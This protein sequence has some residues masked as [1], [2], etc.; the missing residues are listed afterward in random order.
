MTVDEAVE[1][2]WQSMQKGD[3]APEALR[4]ALTLQDAYRVQLALLSR[5]VGAGE[6]LAGWKIGGTSD[7]ARKMLNLTDPVRGYLLASRQFASGHT[8]HRSPSHVSP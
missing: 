7:A 4:K 8:F 5:L 3:H 1:I 6:K 2:L